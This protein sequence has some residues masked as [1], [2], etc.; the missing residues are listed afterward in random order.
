M[1]KILILAIAFAT[2]FTAKSQTVYL[3][4]NGI[5][6]AFNATDQVDMNGTV[7]TAA[8]AVALQNKPVSTVVTPTT[9]TLLVNGVATTFNATDI[10]VLDGVS[11]TAAEAAAKQATVVT[12]KEK[13]P[14]K[15]VRIL[16]VGIS[17]NQNGSFAIA[18]TVSINGVPISVSYQGS[19]PG[20]YAALDNKNWRNAVV[21]QAAYNMQS[22]LT[23]QYSNPAA[24]YNSDFIPSPNVGGAY[25]NTGTTTVTPPGIYR[26]SMGRLY[27]WNGTTR[28]YI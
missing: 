5:A 1:K 19:I 2:S 15:G 17:A 9:V 24:Q 13:D 6:T 8:Q 11:M 20:T 7:M 22:N 3:R 26:D 25:G 18:P 21:N 28:E 12:K 23:G 10:V 27:R 14:N 16:G 4:V